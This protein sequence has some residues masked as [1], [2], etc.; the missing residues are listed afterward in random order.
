MDIDHYAYD[1]TIYPDTSK[2]L[3]KLDLVIPRLSPGYSTLSSLEG[4]TFE[5]VR[6]EFHRAGLKV[7]AG[8]ADKD[9]H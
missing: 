7:A 1:V 8:H 5:A 9:G 6:D 4:I 3:S 2:D